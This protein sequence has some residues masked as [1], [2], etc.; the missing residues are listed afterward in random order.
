MPPSRSPQF[1]AGG[2]GAVGDQLLAGLFARGSGRNHHGDVFD[3]GLVAIERGLGEIDAAPALEEDH[4]GL[5]VGLRQVELGHEAGG[6]V[7]ARLDDGLPQ[8]IDLELLAGLGEIGSEGAFAHAVDLVAAIAV[9]GVEELASA[10]D[11][12]RAGEI[13]RGVALGAVGLHVV[14]ALE[15][16]SEIL[17]PGGLGH[18]AGERLG[19]ELILAVAVLGFEAA[20]LAVVAD[21]AAEVGE[22]VAALP[23][24][25]ALDVAHGGR[26]GMRLERLRRDWRSADRRL[27]MWQ[28]VQRSTRVSPKLVTMVCSM[29]GERASSSARSL[30]I[31]G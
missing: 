8:V 6:Q 16:G 7:G 17:A 28:V 3:V 25:V 14:F 20:A 27:A 2:A 1:V 22:F 11:V 29:R 13:L 31:L 15:L 4:Q 23:V 24:A 12:G 9:H 19:P 5:D 18:V 30:L 26:V 10:I 21:G